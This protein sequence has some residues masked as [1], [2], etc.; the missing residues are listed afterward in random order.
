MASDVDTDREWYGQFYS[1]EVTCTE[2]LPPAMIER[3]TSLP[4]PQLYSLE[5]LYQLAG[6]VEAK[7]IL[8]IACGIENSGILFALKNAKVTMAD[9]AI[10]ALRRQETMAQ[11]NGVRDRVH[12]VV[13]AAQ[14]LPFR[15]SSFDMV[16]G[17]GIWHHLQDDLLTP[18]SE[19][20]RVL[21]TDGCALFSEPIARNGFLQ[22]IRKYVPIEPPRSASPVC[23][24]LAKDALNAFAPQ[25]IIEANYFKFLSRFD[26]LLLPDR[27]KWWRKRMIHLLYW[28]DNLVLCL[29][30][31]DHLAGVV[32]FK[33]TH[34]I[35]SGTVDF[36]AIPDAP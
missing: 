2:P 1:Q 28:L 10:E 33:L 26:R 16:I 35:S 11:I 8:Y 30:A 7:N 20:A 27:K 32:V 29:P 19:V 31:L 25:F 34:R 21:K 14:Q 12:L 3:Y 4:H 9:V 23:R 17:V 18:A 24:P 5:R 36:K 22:W 13:C 6:N 15:C